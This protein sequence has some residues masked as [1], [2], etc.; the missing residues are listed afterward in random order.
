MD[1]PVLKSWLKSFLNDHNLS[2][3][4][5]FIND[6]PIVRFTFSSRICAAL[7]ASFV[8][9]SGSGDPS[10]LRC[11]LSD[12]GGTGEFLDEEPPSATVRLISSCHSRRK[13][14]SSPSNLLSSY[15]GISNLILEYNRYTV[16]GFCHL[17]EGLYI[18]TCQT[19]DPS[20]VV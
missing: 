3:T 17:K 19:P 11:Q 7:M 2:K 10:E 4:N 8:K 14:A 6:V 5:T 1:Y 16:I 13:D 9:G 18:K 20:I 15:I 12:S